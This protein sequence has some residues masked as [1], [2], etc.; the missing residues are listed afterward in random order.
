[1]QIELDD[2]LLPGSDAA[3]NILFEWLKT[4]EDV[5]AFE[6]ISEISAS[7]SSGI[8]TPS[9]DR[10]C[11]EVIVEK[12]GI[13]TSSDDMD[14]ERKRRSIMTWK[15]LILTTKTE[16][17]RLGRLW[18]GIICAW[19]ISEDE[20]KEKMEQ[21]K[22]SEHLEKCLTVGHRILN[23]NVESA[24]KF[25]TFIRVSY[26]NRAFQIKNLLYIFA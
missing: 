7:S 16:K 25:L 2:E 8:T 12:I 10:F 4:T 17:E 5:D 18:N 14:S 22:I 20:E 11:D 24:K 6:L 13:D 9:I 19:E 3:D 26:W 15:S 23:I 1:M 21:R